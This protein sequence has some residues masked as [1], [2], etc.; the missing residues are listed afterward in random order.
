MADAIHLACT[1]DPEEK[2]RRITSLRERVKARDVHRWVEDFLTAAQDVPAPVE[3]APVL[4]L[5][6]RRGAAVARRRSERRLNDATV[7]AGKP[8]RPN[9][10]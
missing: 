7:S 9:S 4:D 5:S 10:A 2:A 8:A 1:M 3:V 6:T